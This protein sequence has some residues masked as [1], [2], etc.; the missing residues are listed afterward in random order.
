MSLNESIV[1][2]FYTLNKSES[3]TYASMPKGWRWVGS[4]STQPLKGTS[5]PTQ[6]EQE[7]QFMGPPSSRSVMKTYLQRYFDRLLKKGILK[8]YKIRYS[9]LP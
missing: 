3:W 6:Y 7:E 8:R 4:G 9:Y 1:F 5:K 2:V